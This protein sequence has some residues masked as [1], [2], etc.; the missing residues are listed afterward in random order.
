[1]ISIPNQTILLGSTDLF[2]AFASN[3]APTQLRADATATPP[4]GVYRGYDRREI[5]QFLLSG[6]TRIDRLLGG[7]A[8]VSGEAGFKYIHDLPDVNER[9]YGRSD[10]YGLG[11]VNGVCALGAAPS[12]CSSEGFAT[13]FSWGYRARIAVRYPHVLADVALIPAV[14]FQHDVKGY[15]HDAVFLK[16]RKAGIVSLRAE[17]NQLFV[18]AGWTAVWGGDYNYTKDRDFYSIVAGLRF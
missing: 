8:T 9:R 1:L 12:Q 15:A 14:A 10:V 18:E 4:G 5:S 13:A 3:V 6:R 17:L 16:G 2:N 7:T 11:P